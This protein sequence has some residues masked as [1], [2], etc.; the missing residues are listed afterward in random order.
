MRL[1]DF[2]ALPEGSLSDI[3]DYGGNS[4]GKSQLFWQDDLW[5]VKYP[6]N[7]VE[8]R[9]DRTKVLSYDTSPVSEWLGSRVYADI[10]IPVQET[11]LGLL[12]GRVVV[13]CKHLND[14]DERLVTFRG[15][16]RAWREK[17]GKRLSRRATDRHAVLDD[18]FKIIEEE[19]VYLNLGLKEHFWDMFVVDSLIGNHD[20]N[21]GN[22]GIIQNQRNR[23]VRLSPVFDNAGSF[24]PQWTQERMHLFLGNPK[25]ARNTLL[26]GEGSPFLDAD[27]DEVQPIRFPGKTSLLKYRDDFLNAIKRV[28]PAIDMSSIFSAIEELEIES[29]ITA[30]TADLYRFAVETRYTGRLLPCLEKALAAEPGK[31]LDLRF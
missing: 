24:F 7:R 21:T 13:A 26:K 3:A 25:N 10:G 18:I 4:C 14:P 19:P 9:K 17:P 11:E 6:S 22:W 5:M 29:V 31:A 1:N 20:R 23:N 28:V 8:K 15:L 12:R 27:G 16:M 2:D 30:R